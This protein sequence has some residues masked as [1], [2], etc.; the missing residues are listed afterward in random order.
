MKKTILTMAL[1]A[2]SAV[3]TYADNYSYLTFEG[4]DGAQLSI[5]VDNL[6]ITFSDGRL[7]ASNGSESATLS[8][9][10]LY[11]M[12][13]SGTTG[14]DNVAAPKADAVKAYSLSGVCVGTYSNAAA[15][16]AALPKGVYILKNGDAAK[17]IT[18][19]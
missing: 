18:V 10:T 15:A 8:V 14:V 5:G 11:K 4:L 9:A 12:F 6:K 7:L 13:F 19:R 1:A 17:K 3:G 2:I 16:A